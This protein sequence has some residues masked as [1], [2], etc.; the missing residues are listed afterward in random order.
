[1]NQSATR[2]WL[3]TCYE[4]F[5]TGR[6][7]VDFTFFFSPGDRSPSVTTERQRIDQIGQQNKFLIT[8]TI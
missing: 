3:L 4:I 6:L 1:M 8:L 7:A 2:L 5:I